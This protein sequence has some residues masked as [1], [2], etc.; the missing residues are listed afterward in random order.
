M[1]CPVAND[2]KR[3]FAPLGLAI[4]VVVALTGPRLVQA[5]PAT[6]C[7]SVV[8]FTDP[9]YDTRVSEL[10]SPQGHQHNIY[11]RRDIWN[12]DDSYMLGVRTDL[13]GQN[14]RLTLYTGDGCFVRE[15]YNLA[16]F[17]WRVVWDRHNPALL[18]TWK[19]SDL[20]RF[21]V[22]TGRAE[23]LKSFA[24]LGF[25]PTG[26]SLNQSGDRILMITTD[27]VYHSY[28]LS[29]MDDERTFRATYPMNCIAPGKDERYIGYQNYIVASCATRDLSLQVLTVY[30]D[31]GAV[32]SRITTDDPWKSLTGHL[33]FSP[34]GKLAYFRMWGGAHRE[35]LP[36]EIH[37]ANLDGSN[38]RVV[39]SVEQAQAQ[40][41][42][43]LHLSWP[44]K[45]RDWFVASFYPAPGNM[46]PTYQAPLDEIMQLSISGKKR[47]LARTQTVPGRG[48]DFWAQPLASPSA[49]GSRICFNSNHGG[50]IEQYI[51]WVPQDW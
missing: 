42:Q 43:N 1:K 35:H 38:D 27:G 17:D 22:D 21:D 50:N 44:A 13:N 23:L 19:N 32:K 4:I 14:W 51:L 15:L 3:F 36:L 9:T 45:V 49:D 31:T 47:Y 8:A 30:D 12:A 33:A 39:Y 20:Y 11:Y 6:S 46:P 24:P 25:L 7:A 10:K 41:V 34:D 18:Y 48:F 16:Q 5:A 28:R 37:V 40:W 29:G 26:P 2:R